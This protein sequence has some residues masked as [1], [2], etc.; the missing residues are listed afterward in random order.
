M[1]RRLNDIFWMIFF[2]RIFFWTTSLSFFAL[3]F[4]FRFSLSLPPCLSLSFPF[5]S[6]KFHVEFRITVRIGSHFKRRFKLEERNAFLFGCAC[7]F[8]RSNVS[9][10]LVWSGRKKPH[11]KYGQS[12]SFIKGREKGNRGRN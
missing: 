9:F 2:F 11:R 8:L 3:V 7:G 12:G 4:S 6:N 5:S 10:H 1:N